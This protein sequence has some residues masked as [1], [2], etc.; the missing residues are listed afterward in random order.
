[1]HCTLISGH[2]SRAT[3]VDAAVL[4]PPQSATGA[5]GALA[6]PATATAFG[7]RLLPQT[8]AAVL[9]GH[10]V[11][12]PSV[13]HLAAAFSLPQLAVACAALAEP[14]VAAVFASQL[15]PAAAA[16]AQLATTLS[17]QKP[18][19]GLRNAAVLS[20]LQLR[21]LI[22]SLCF[23]EIQLSFIRITEHTF[24]FRFSISR[25]LNPPPTSLSVFRYSLSL[26][27]WSTRG[28]SQKFHFT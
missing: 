25:I 9:A 15:L 14:V 11:R 16:C 28:W 22:K 27:A 8:A 10:A 18:T 21:T 23:L 17:V 3:A 20:Q 12:A 26:V 2:A 6:E 4:S 13:E 1:M 5:L 24:V 19:N 7:A